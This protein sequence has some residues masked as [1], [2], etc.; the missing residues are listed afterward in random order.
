M[1]TKNHD[2]IVSI[3]PQQ[4]SPSD[5]PSSAENKI[6]DKYLII[7]AHSMTRI[8]VGMNHP[9]PSGAIQMDLPFTVLIMMFSDEN[10]TRKYRIN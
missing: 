1:T 6:R 5:A 4:P 7:Y 10:T 8:Y 2:I 9:Q 3:Q